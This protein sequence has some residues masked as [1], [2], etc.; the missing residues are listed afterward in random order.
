MLLNK[1]LC[2]MGPDDLLDFGPAVTEEETPECVSLLSAVIENA[3]VLRNMSHDGFRGS[4]LLRKGALSAGNGSW[5]LRVE[6]QTFD[7]VLDRFPWSF[8]WIK[9][10]WMEVP[11]AVEW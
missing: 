6:H 10:P 5:L 11:L 2:G 7:V 9:L 8:S 3:P 1:M 4:F